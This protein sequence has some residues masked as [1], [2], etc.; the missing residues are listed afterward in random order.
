MSRNVSYILSALLRPNGVTGRRQRDWPRPRSP[1]WSALPL[2]V[3]F[4]HRA[5]RQLQRNCVV[6]PHPCRD[7][8]S[9]LRAPSR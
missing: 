4:A 1:G 7:E 6:S 5:E 9:S 2:A 3:L 8:G